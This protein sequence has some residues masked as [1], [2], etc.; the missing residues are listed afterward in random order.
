[1]RL[2]GLSMWVEQS[3]KHAL[4]WSQYQVRSDRAMRRH[5]QLVCCAFSFCWYHASHPAA[6]SLQEPAKEADSSAGPE[7]DVPAGEAGT[8]VRTW[9]EP[10][11]MLRQYWNGSSPLPPPP[12]LQLLLTW[13]ERGQALFL[14]SS[15]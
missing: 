11:I 6:E 5:W 14:Y 10:W 15:A 8:A 7:A 13:L 1:V 4:G 3:Y 2:S 9:L 12:P